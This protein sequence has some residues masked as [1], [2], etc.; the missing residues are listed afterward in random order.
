MDRKIY[1]FITILIFMMNLSMPVY[2][3]TGDIG[4]IDYSIVE[5]LHPLKDYFLYSPN[6][7]LKPVDSIEKINDFSEK[8]NLELK[9]ASPIAISN[10]EKL[11]HRKMLILKRIK[12]IEE[13]VSKKNEGLK[14][15]FTKIYSLDNSKE[16]K[17]KL[18]KIRKK[19]R[20]LKE[21]T[22]YKKATYEVQ[23]KNCEEKIFFT[24][25]K[26]FSINYLKKEETQKLEKIIKEEINKAIKKVC[27]IK[28]ISSV[29]NISALKIKRVRNWKD[30]VDK[31]WMAPC[32]KWQNFYFIYREK[33]DFKE[34]K[35]PDFIKSD[36]K[37]KIFSKIKEDNKIKY[38]KLDNLI[39]YGGKKITFLVLERILKKYN[40]PKIKRLLIKEAVEEYLEN[41]AIK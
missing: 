32:S 1:L 36:Y 41:E 38:Q 7:Y 12:L 24:K 31:F 16:R 22:G 15:K 10:I 9:N 18:S 3:K 5:A 29:I 6:V 25:E 40:Y 28:R 21:Q 26:I 20:L 23:F 39:P 2:G 11:N 4:I 27:K 13:N 35:V 33:T 19:M 17:I 30:I 14:S 34:K 8:R 37:F